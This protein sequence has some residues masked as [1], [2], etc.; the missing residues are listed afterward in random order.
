MRLRR[1]VPRPDVAD[2]P[3]LAAMLAL[4]ALCVLV[5]QHGHLWW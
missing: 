2:L 1:H 3:L 4:A 5:F